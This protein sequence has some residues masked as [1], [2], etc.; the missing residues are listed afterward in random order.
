MIHKKN[1]K[2]DRK[3]KLLLHGYGHYGLPLDSEFNIV[4]L[5]A[6]EEDWVLAYAHVRGGNEKG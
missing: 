2:K 5:K 6:L 1:L 3:N 4:Y